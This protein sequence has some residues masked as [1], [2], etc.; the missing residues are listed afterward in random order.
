MWTGLFRL[1]RGPMGD[2]C[3]HSNES[4]GSTKVRNFLTGFLVSNTTKHKA[5][6]TM[7]TQW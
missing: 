5:L 3:E 7:H 1:R 4:V 6:K 2:S